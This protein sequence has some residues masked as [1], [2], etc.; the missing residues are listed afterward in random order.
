MK[1]IIPLLIFCFISNTAHSQPNYGHYL[2]LEAGGAMPVHRTPKQ[3]LKRFVNTPIN[4]TPS[5]LLL[6]HAGGHLQSL[7]GSFLEVLLQYRRV[8][9]DASVLLG[10]RLGKKHD[11]ASWFVETNYGGTNGTL[12]SHQSYNESNAFAYGAGIRYLLMQ[13]LS[14][15]MTLIRNHYRGF[16]NA[17]PPFNKPARLLVGG[18]LHWHLNFGNASKDQPRTPPKVKKLSRR[19]QNRCLY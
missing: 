11:R 17:N 14:L 2:F 10:L 15:Q 7:N 5:N 12:L 13:H 3:V 4:W 6:L 19:S 18:S 1:P 9:T 8:A 16:E